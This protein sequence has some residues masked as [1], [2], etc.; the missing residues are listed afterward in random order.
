MAV[1]VEVNLHEA[2]I[3]AFYERHFGRE[4]RAIV[5]EGVR[6]SRA[7][8]PRHR[9]DLWRSIEG[10]VE[11]YGAPDGG[12]LG[13]WG[14]DEPHA[15]WVH[16]GTGIYGPRRRPIRPRSG[17]YLVFTPY[18]LIG[19]NKRGTARGRIPR[20]RR[21][22]IAVTQVRGQPRTPFLTEPFEE[23]LAA[24]GLAARVTLDLAIRRLPGALR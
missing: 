18:R 9:G 17:R 23:V 21:R 24:H 20:N 4:V 13:Y 16:D 14:T 15:M 11:R 10:D 1:S 3:Q 19:A 2:H 8:A 12:Y 22:V 5:R 7:R 6:L